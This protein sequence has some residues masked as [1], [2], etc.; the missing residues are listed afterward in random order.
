MKYDPTG[1]V[2]ARLNAGLAVE[3]DEAEGRLTRESVECFAG[4]VVE[5]GSEVEFLLAGFSNEGC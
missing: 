4:H 1:V 5:E 3:V 2:R